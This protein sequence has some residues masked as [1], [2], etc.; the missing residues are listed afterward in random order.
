MSEPLYITKDGTLERRENTIYFENEHQKYPIPVEQISEIY[1][2][3]HVSVTSGVI[4]FLATKEIPVHFFNHY[5]YFESSL[6]PKKKEVS[7]NIIVSQVKSYLDSET[8]YRIASSFVYGAAMNIINVLKGQERTENTNS[9]DIEEIRTYIE[10][11][12]TSVPSISS[13]MGLEGNIR[14]I[15]YK[16]MDK[17]LPEW[18]SLGSRE[19]HPTKNP[20]NALMSFC[21]SLA[22]TACLT[23]IYHTQLNPTVSFLHEPGERRFSLSLDISEIFKPSI[24]DRIFL[25]LINRNQ[26]DESHFDSGI[27]NVRLSEKGKKL[28]L[29][30]FQD[31]ME[32]TIMHRTLKRSVKYRRL[33]RIEC[34]KILNDIMIGEVYKPLISWW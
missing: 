5:G 16:S 1:C 24:T 10:E 21:N 34:F 28:V 14:R 20:G 13:L 12:P 22:Y 27:G 25:K 15:Y 26:L 23:E 9:K 29:K 2:M 8:R 31:K 3:S 7:G 17:N 11:I 33:I 19:Y 4:H 6:L 32:T 18:L 30:E